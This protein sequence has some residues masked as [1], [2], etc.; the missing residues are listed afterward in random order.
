MVFGSNTKDKRL[1]GFLLEEKSLDMEGNTGTGLALSQPPMWEEAEEPLTSLR[2]TPALKCPGFLLSAS[3]KALP[4][5]WRTRYAPQIR[6]QK[7]VRK[8]GTAELHHAVSGMAASSSHR[9]H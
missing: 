9:P 3:H 7:V 6:R 5:T 4:G 8:T 2:Q 1:P